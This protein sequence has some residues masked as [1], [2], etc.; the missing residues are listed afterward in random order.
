MV[1]DIYGN[2]YVG[3]YYLSGIYRLETNGL[4]ETGKMMLVK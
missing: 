2:Y 3:G 4:S 1:K